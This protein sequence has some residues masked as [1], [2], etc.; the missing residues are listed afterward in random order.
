MKAIGIQCSLIGTNPIW[1]DSDSDSSS[2]SDDEMCIDEDYKAESSDT[3]SDS[4]EASP[5]SLD[6]K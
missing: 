5:T 1:N 2:S 6:D 4:E 3:N